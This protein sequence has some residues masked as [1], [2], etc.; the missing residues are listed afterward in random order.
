[1]NWNKAFEIIKISSLIIITWSIW[2]ISV[3]FQD[4]IESIHNISNVLGHN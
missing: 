1:M 2:N 3:H 4:L